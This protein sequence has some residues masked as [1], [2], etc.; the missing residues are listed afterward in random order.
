MTFINPT[1]V[2]LEYP[3]E[4]L[5]DALDKLYL[6]GDRVKEAF[7]ANDETTTSTT[8]TDL[9]TIGPSIPF[10]PTTSRILLLWSVQ[11]RNSVSLGAG[12]AS[13]Q[14]LDNGISV[15][16]ATDA[17][18]TRSAVVESA[19]GHSPSG[20]GACVYTIS[21]GYPNYTVRLR[22]RSGTGTSN[23]LSRRLILIQL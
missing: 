23:F 9:A 18:D 7:L 4:T 6:R 13:P 14:L 20:F 17:N 12:Y 3:L 1:R 8:Y 10:V 11:S 2:K 21:A 5:T 16:P 15:G 22:Y 19:S